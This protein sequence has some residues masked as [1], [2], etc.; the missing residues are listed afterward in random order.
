MPL[1]DWLEKKLNLDA[2]QLEDYLKNEVESVEK[3][4]T[5]L[6]IYSNH[7]SKRDPLSFDGISC[8]PLSEIKINSGGVECTLV[9]FL[10]CKYG[11]VVKNTN[12]PCLIQRNSLL[13][14]D[15]YYPLNFIL[16]DRK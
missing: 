4:L 6:P 16:V 1:L 12:Y 9:Q 2:S 15:S 7:T 10:Y 13:G 11:L 8:C 3:L 14:I 5:S